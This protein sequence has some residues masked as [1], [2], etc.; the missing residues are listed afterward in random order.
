MK[1]K[2]NMSS[3]RVLFVAKL[4]KFFE[5]ETDIH[6][7]YDPIANPSTVDIRVDD[8][9]KYD[10]LSK[11]L[12]DKIDFGNVSL[13]INVI[14]A[15]FDKVDRVAL[16]KTLL[17]NMSIVEAVDEVT[18]EGSSNSFI[19]ASFRN[20]VVKYWSD[21]LGNPHGNSFTLYETLANEIFQNHDGILFTTAEE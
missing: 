17:Q 21:N 2:V 10:T 19:Y 15:N 12:D 3:P 9:I 7:N 4:K 18:I 8:P 1:I 5:E 16:F 11:L 13:N 14:P 6:I 20:Q